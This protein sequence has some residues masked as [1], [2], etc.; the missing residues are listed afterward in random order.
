MASD[1]PSHPCGDV[2]EVVG[3][4]SGNRGRSCEEHAVCGKALFLDSVVRIPKIQ[5]LNGKLVR[6][7]RTDILNDLCR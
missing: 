1:E 3:V 5:I 6:I 4:A 2:V 7:K